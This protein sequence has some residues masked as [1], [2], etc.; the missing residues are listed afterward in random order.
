MHQ[1][2]RVMQVD[3]QDRQIVKTIGACL[4]SE[5]NGQLASEAGGD[6]TWGLVLHL[7]NVADLCWQL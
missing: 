2:D 3:R 5:Q 4:G 6:A 1:V 7:H